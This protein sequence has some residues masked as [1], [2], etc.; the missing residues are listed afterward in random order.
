MINP[1]GNPP[2][3]SK[4]D[5]TSSLRHH[6]QGSRRCVFQH[7]PESNK[8]R[9]TEASQPS[10]MMAES[11]GLSTFLIHPF[12]P[13]PQLKQIE[14]G[15]RLTWTCERGSPGRELAALRISRMS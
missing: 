11:T 8:K 4:A 14:G 2:S 5:L 15:S 6:H 7:C 13:T 9:D 3:F 12:P 1:I 10:A